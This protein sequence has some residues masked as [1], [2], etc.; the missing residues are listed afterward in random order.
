VDSW[1]TL[2]GQR[3]QSIEDRM[4]APQGAVLPEPGAHARFVVLRIDARGTAR[5]ARAAT[6]MP[7]LVR[8]VAA[9]DPMAGLVAN[10]GL[11]ASFWDVVSPTRRPG[12]L[13]PFRAL[14]VDGRRAP[15]TGGDLFVHVTSAR[16]DLNAAVVLQV[17]AEVGDVATVLEDVQGF[18]YLDSRDLTGFIDG[19]ENPTGDGRADAALLGDEDATFA[20]G[21]YVFTQRYVHDLRAWQALGVS[22][23][24]GVIGRR[25]SDSAELPADEKPATAHISRVVIEENGAELEI[26]RHS[27]PYAT[28]AEAGLFFVA[29]TRDLSI[30]DRMLGLMMGAATDGL[31]DHLMSYTR[32][33]SGATFF[34]P[35]LEVL[36]E[37]A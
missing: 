29:Y 7:E 24:E 11:G 17:M 18:R 3:S 35:S 9:A 28:A 2:T 36:A 19:T 27:M 10:V 5:A 37:L 25:K 34:V 15:A 14:D 20:A 4:A 21:S 16:A 23:Q 26:L 13:R 31:H 32:A 8:D 30:P 22:E 33:V 6:A 1:P 12:G